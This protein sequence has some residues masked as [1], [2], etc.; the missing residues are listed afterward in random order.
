MTAKMIDGK[1]I[2][3]ELREEIKEKVAERAAAGKPK[4]GLATVLIG[5]D[6]ASEVYVGM[7]K[8]MCERLGMNSFSYTL[9]ADA[10]Q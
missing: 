7:K 6:P 3:K 5:S 2:A 9:P 1:A 10:S 8:R 4:P